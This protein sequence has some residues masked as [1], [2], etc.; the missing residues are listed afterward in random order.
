MGLIR[1]REKES[2]I[3]SSTVQT[4]RAST[5]PFTMLE[6]YIPLADCQSQLYMAMREAVPIIDAAIFKLVRLVGEFNVKCRSSKSQ[7]ALDEFL[8][9]VCVNGTSVGIDAF[10]SS[11]FEQLLTFGTAVGEIITAQGRV[12]ALYNAD[13]SCIELRQGES[14][15]DIKI[16]N[17]NGGTPVPV[18]YQNLIL[19]SLLNPQAGR[20]SGNSILNGLPFV[21]SVLLKIYNTIGINWERVGNV[22][23]AVTYKPQNDGMDRAYAKQRAMQVAKEWGEAMHGGGAVK[24]FVAVGDVQ[25]KAIGADNQI[26]DSEVPVR[27]LLEQIVAKT[28]LPPFMLGLSWSATERMSSQQADVLTSEL[29]AYR[30]ILNPIVKKICDTFLRFEGLDNSFEICWNDVTLQ[31]EVELSRARLYNAQADRIQAELKTIQSE[32][33]D[34]QY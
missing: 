18:K 16:C 4:G 14:P 6:S 25:I 17:T 29:E 11:Y 5:H 22:R 24:D 12:C 20:L 27:Q 8:S 15:L 28:G 23:F 9:T 21:S 3:S 34:E 26:L 7:K 33:G 19:L 31:D 1:K 10:V 30:R 32:Q 13:L 2:E